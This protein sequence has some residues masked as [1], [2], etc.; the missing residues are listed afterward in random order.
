MEGRSQRAGSGLPL[1]GWLYHEQTRPFPYAAVRLRVSKPSSRDAC[2]LRR[3][4]RSGSPFS[5]AEAAPNARSQVNEKPP[6]HWK[7][8]V[9][10]ITGTGV[11]T[12]I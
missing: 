11:L 3:R 5:C 12:A 1:Q 7:P 6:G 2:E 10:N 9:R 4:G 8:L